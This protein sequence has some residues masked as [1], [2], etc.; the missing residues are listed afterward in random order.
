[1]NTGSTLARRAM[2]RELRRM[3]ESARLSQAAAARVAEVSQQTI[4]RMEEG[5][6]TQVSGLHINALCNAFG[7]SDE[8]RRT[9][10]DL[11]REVK[12][13][14][15]LGGGWWKSFADTTPEG[16]DHYLGLEDAASKLTTWKIAVV[17]G[18]L[19]TPEYRRALIW[20]EDPARSTGEVEKRI[21]MATQ[22]QIRLQ[23][24]GFTMEVLLAESVLRDEIGGRSVMGAQLRHLSAAALLPNVSIRVVP[25]AAPGHLGS[26]VGSFVLLQFP[27]LVVSKLNE[28]PIVY[29][30]GYVGDLY[31][32]RD[33][34]VRRYQD[35]LTEIRRVALDETDTR[36]LISAVVKEFGA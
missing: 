14:R 13:A 27:P 4:G 9:V 29:V 17:P 19:Q 34:E 21:A 7:A 23:E 22:R 1:M 24:P 26:F 10:L 3:R 33:R 31:L 28:P 2:G 25:F 32:E 18:L 8:E 20:A 30:E 11:L 15:E 36:Q 5:R 12:Q 16:F 6:P 35:A